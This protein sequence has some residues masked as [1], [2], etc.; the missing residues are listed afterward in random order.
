MART[1]P[2][3]AEATATL[4]APGQ[5]FEME[6]LTI[7]GIPTRT[8]KSAP[9][10][11]RTVLELSAHHGDKDFLVYEDERM[12]FAE[13][14][15]AVTALAHV[16]VERFGITKGD[17]VAIAMRNLPEW[18]I[19]FWASISIGAVVVPLNAWWTGPELAYG[20]SDSGASLLFA[21]EERQRR[22]LP[23][24]G[25]IPA[26]GAI[27]VCCEEPGPD[28]GRRA[29]AGPPWTGRGRSRCRWCRWPS[30]PDATAGD[31]TLPD[32]DIDPDDDATIF[33]TSGTTGKPKGAVGTHRNSALESDEPLLRGHGGRPAPRRAARRQ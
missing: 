28:G 9:S 19:A 18:V 2:S 30:S 31:P 21:D 17:R 7:R 29:A 14:F 8:W 10:T 4:T 33:Y 27:V 12:T 20:L 1:I 13:H 11:L 22:V 32:V 16:L 26:L 5:L 15:H 24:L 25:E 3:L 6:D 23:H